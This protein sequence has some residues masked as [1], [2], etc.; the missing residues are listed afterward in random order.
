MVRLSERNPSPFMKTDFSFKLVAAIVI[1]GVIVALASPTHPVEVVA[2]TP[3]VAPAA[4]HT[5]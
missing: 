5:Q 3:E 1:A 4:G 2:A